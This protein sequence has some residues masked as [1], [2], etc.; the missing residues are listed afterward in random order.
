MA[1]RYRP[2]GWQGSLGWEAASSREFAAN[3]IGVAPRLR[4]CVA[5]VSKPKLLD[6]QER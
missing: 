6:L 3:P 1:L 2:T 4:R 5:V